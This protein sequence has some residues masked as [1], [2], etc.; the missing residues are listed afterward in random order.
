MVES[1]PKN[2]KWFGIIDRL[3]KASTKKENLEI[4]SGLK[5]Y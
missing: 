4:L 5:K 1:I 3:K 2:E